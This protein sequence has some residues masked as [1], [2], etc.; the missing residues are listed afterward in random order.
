MSS[1][2][3]RFGPGVTS[4]LGADLKNLGAK[5]ICVV[6]DTNVVKLPSVKIAFDSLTA[7]GVQ[8]EVF[9]QTR[10][11]P[12]DGS[13]WEAANFA[14]SRNFDAFVAIGGGSA[15]DTCKAANLYASDPDAEFLD[16]VNKPIGKGKEVGIIVDY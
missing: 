10:V 12:T 3:V 7:N 9:D 4:E 8:F 2:T 16:Y 15:I 1:S 11:E 5:N 6:S 14:K 13:L